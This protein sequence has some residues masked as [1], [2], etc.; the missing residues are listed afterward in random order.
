[1]FS[2]RP[3]HTTTDLKYFH[4]KLGSLEYEHARIK[5]STIPEKFVEEHNLHDLVD[6]HRHFFAGARGL[7]CGLPHTGLLDYEDLASHLS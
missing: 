7:M 5:L 1:M 6:E 4:I 3:R 2:H